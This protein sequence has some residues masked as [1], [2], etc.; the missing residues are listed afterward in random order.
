M[1]G[2]LEWFQMWI[3]LN[4]LQL[5]YDSKTKLI[6]IKLVSLIVLQGVPQTIEIVACHFNNCIN[7]FGTNMCWPTIQRVEFFSCSVDLSGSN[8]PCNIT[9]PT[10]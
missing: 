9:P 5:R 3:Q 2:T 4:Q 8:L 10:S 6:D 1:F 7:Y